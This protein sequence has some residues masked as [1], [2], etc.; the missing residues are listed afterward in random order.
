[1]VKEAVHDHPFVRQGIRG[2]D[3]RRQVVHVGRPVLVASEGPGV[4]LP[5]EAKGIHDPVGAV[6]G[7]P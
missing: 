2:I 1:M 5:L 7:Q 6:T 3:A 4:A